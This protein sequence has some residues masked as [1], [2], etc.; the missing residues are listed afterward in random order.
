MSES[1]RQPG[2]INVRYHRRM[3]GTNVMT[4]DASRQ[5][6][7]APTCC[8]FH[9]QIP[10][11]ERPQRRSQGRARSGSGSVAIAA[12]GRP[13]WRNFSRKRRVSSRKAPRRH[14]LAA[15]VSAASCRARRRT[16][17][18]TH[19]LG[20]DDDGARR[21][22]RL[23]GWRCRRTPDQRRDPRAGQR[24]GRLLLAGRPVGI[25][26]DYGRLAGRMATAVQGRQPPST[27][28]I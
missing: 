11:R 9:T 1:S 28:M 6:G 13:W 15:R 17:H 19:F 27:Q 21:L 4:P 2:Y 26:Y 24:D 3:L 20:G 10:R 7:P 14:R 22:F 23:V 18:A 25:G 16:V 5:D 12:P 8:T